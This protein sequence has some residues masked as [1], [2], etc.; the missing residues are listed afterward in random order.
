M[1]ERFRIGGVG[2]EAHETLGRGRFQIRNADS[3]YQGADKGD[4]LV[5][6]DSPG[7]GE[8]ED[9]PGS[10]WCLVLA[11][12]Q[13]SRAEP[14]SAMISCRLGNNE[15]GRPNQRPGDARRPKRCP[16]IVFPEATIRGGLAVHENAAYWIQTRG[17]V[18]YRPA[19]DAYG[20]LICAMS[21][22]GTSL[23]PSAY[24]RFGGES[25]PNERVESL[26]RRGRLPQ[27]SGGAGGQPIAVSPALV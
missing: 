3:Q 26:R 13:A 18:E 23:I 10:W 9:N 25:T 6:G 11:S 2:V 7:C 24:A 1:A 8:P 19:D 15:D 22:C 4:G 5:H 14:V 21:S 20:A 16:R 12:L 17:A 27:G